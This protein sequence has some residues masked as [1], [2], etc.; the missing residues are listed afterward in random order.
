MIF[1]SEVNEGR[2]LQVDIGNWI[3]MESLERY[4][5]PHTAQWSFSG[6]N[7]QKKKNMDNHAQLSCPYTQWSTV[8]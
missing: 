7:G 1:H 3:R 8:Q 2:H 6:L 5:A 4:A